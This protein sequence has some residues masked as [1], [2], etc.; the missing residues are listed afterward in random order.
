MTIAVENE[1]D[2]WGYSTVDIRGPAE[3]HEQLYAELILPGP[4]PKVQLHATGEGGVAAANEK[5]I[6]EMTYRGQDGRQHGFNFSAA[7]DK[8]GVAE[9][10]FPRD[11]PLATEAE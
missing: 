8:E 9:V 4:V 10:G 1:D 6:G 11:L 5:L 7:L 3:K 2:H